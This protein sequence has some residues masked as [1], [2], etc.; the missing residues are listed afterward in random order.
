VAENKNAQQVKEITDKLENGIRDF[1]ESEKFQQYLKT[2][3]KFYD[4]SINNCILIAMQK[5][6]ATL[7]AGYTSWQK[8]FGRQ[9]QKGEKGIKILAP[10]P[11]KTK[12]LKDKLDPISKEPIIGADGAPEKES[13]EVLRPAFKVVSV[14]DVSQTEGRDI[15]SLGINEL[16]GSV[17][18]YAAFF[19]A[20]NFQSPVPIGF[21][22]IKGGAKG[23]YHQLERR[24]AI[25]EGM[26]EIQTIK[27][28]IHE[29]A[30]AKLH[31]I[32]PDKLVP[33]T[34]KDSFTKEVEAESVAYTV[35][36]RYGI[37]TSEYSFGYIA[38]WSTSKET[39]ELKDSL[40]TIRSTAADM[41]E[42]IDAKLKEILAEKEAEKTKP[43]S[44]EVAVEFEGKGFIEAHEDELGMS[45]SVYDLNLKHIDGGFF[46]GEMTAYEAVEMVALDYDYGDINKGSIVFNY[47]DF[48]DAVA[49]A[50]QIISNYA[51]IPLYKD[52]AEHATATGEYGSFLESYRINGLC[53]FA[54]EEAINSGYQDNTLSSTAAKDVISQFGEERVAYVLANSI[55]QKNWDGRISDDNKAWAKSYEI[56]ADGAESFA[57]TAVHPGL[58]NVFTNQFRAEIEQVH[59]AEMPI[60]KMTPTDRKIKDAVMDVLKDQIAYRNDGMMSQYKASDQSFRTL[61]DHQVKIDGDTVTQNSE[62]IFA[63]QRRISERKTKG[64][65]RELTPKLEFIKRERPSIHEKLKTAAAQQ[66][67]KPT[68]A[69]KKEMER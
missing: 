27:T 25:Q 52:N 3:S 8:N 30:H 67:S 62:P 40:E 51:N 61:A 48:M 24:I 38:G 66:V 56:P 68:Q 53:R 49:D 4:Y 65:Y 42:G 50:N 1:F 45:F 22:E 23:Y 37:D 39:K 18:N 64:C 5:P 14:F 7:V 36:Q 54:I 59:V 41:I 2:M 55:Q 13:V 35:C 33:E 58:L 69:K 29:I 57:V 15:P 63:I 44:K 20:L 11:Y 26:S 9:V 32:N 16:E 47:N 10:A 17:E 19:E 28:A 6:E 46:D 31:A 60:A 34:V 21:E 43:W 12:I